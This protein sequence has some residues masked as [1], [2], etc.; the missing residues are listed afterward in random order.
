MPPPFFFLVVP[1][2]LPAGR[3]KP[4]GPP[5]SLPAPG[6]G[7]SDVLIIHIFAE[8]TLRSGQRRHISHVYSRTHL[9]R[10]L[11]GHSMLSAGETA[12]RGALALNP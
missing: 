2:P 8:R 12:H 7:V 11:V 3:G 1:R 10:A 6:G 4:A 9:V 5:S